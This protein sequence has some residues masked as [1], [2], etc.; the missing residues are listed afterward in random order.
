M[1]VTLPSLGHFTGSENMY[2]Q[3]MFKDINYTDGVRYVMQD[4][5]A[6]LVTDI[7]AQLKLNRNLHGFEFIVIE[8]DP[9]KKTV[10]YK[11][12]DRKILSQKYELTDLVVP[13]KFYFFNYG[14]EGKRLILAS[15]Y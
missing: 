10:T 13:V 12:D 3:P 1:P 15:E 8:F 5:A 14:E 11:D 6:W 7:L 4:G 2:F 9:N